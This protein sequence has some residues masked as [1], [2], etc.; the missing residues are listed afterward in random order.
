MTEFD[1]TRP[2]FGAAGRLYYR[3]FGM[4]GRVVTHD[5]IAFFMRL[6]IAGVFWRSLL[7]KVETFG[8]L[9]YTELINDFPVERYHLKLPA[10]PLDLRP[11]TITQFRND[12]AL[13]LIP[14]DVAAWMATLGEFVLPILLVFGLLTRFAAAGLLAMT[15]VIQIFVFPGAWWSAHA[16]WAALLIYLIARGGGGWS[17]DHLASRFVAARHAGD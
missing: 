12:F 6:T 17:L 4:I 5:V 1:H 10:L 2:L 8:L 9:G 11:A 14:A 3:V 7:T 15:L 16:L 13:P